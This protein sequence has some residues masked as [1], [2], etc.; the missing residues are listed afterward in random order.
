MTSV[1]PDAQLVLVVEDYSDARE[2]VAEY[3][4]EVGFRVKVARNGAEA[5]QAAG[6]H[7]PDV[8]LMDLSLPVM[9]GWEA[10]RRL[11][12]DARTRDIPVMALSGHV[13]LSHAEVAREAG[14]DDFVTKP[15]MPEELEARIRAML[16]PS[17]TKRRP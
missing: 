15:C 2:M 1:P 12:G 17:Q 9:D 13:S 7:H 11:K 5:L 10:T 3:L 8:I 16:K 6:D 4:E 14:A